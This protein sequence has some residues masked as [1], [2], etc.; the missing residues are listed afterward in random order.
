MPRDK[1]L[2]MTFPNDFWQHPKIAPL[3]DAAFRAFVEMNGYS[4]MQ[5]LDGR[6]PV[7][8][9][10][11]TWKVKPTTELTSNHPERPTLT[12]DGDVYVIWNYEEHQQTKA[13]RAAAAEVS[14]TN[15]R[16]SGG[17]P[18]HNPDITQPGYETEP[19]ANPDKSRGRGRDR[20]KDTTPL[21]RGVDVTPMPWC[22]KHPGGTER[23]CGPCRTARMAFEVFESQSKAAS[24][25]KA[26]TATPRR[27]VPGDGHKH[28]VSPG[29]DR[30]EL[31]E[32]RIT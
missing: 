29:G 21:N 20:D 23:A 24:T 11:K 32:M 28:R 10:N 5:D 18:K 13:I 7:V 9:A 14:R 27:Y 12:L 30:C 26:V 3:S 2:Y 8:Y 25:V 15:G 17:R 4:R 31:C 1:R 19:E 16:L 22:I 6:I